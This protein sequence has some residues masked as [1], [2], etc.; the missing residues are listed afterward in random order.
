[1]LK[2][3][4][5]PAALLLAAPAL[6]QQK[7]EQ[8]LDPNCPREGSDRPTGPLWLCNGRL[9]PDYA[10]AFVYPAAATQNPALIALLREQAEADQA[11]MAQES[12][13]F[14]TERPGLFT[15][16]AEWRMDALTPELAAASGTLR[17]YTGGAH[18]GLEYRAI[19]IDRR[20]GHRIALNELFAPNLFEHSLFGRKI[21]GI[22]AVQASFCRALTAQVRERR[23]QPAA[24]VACPDIEDQ[25]VTFVCSA[26][27]RIEAMRALI[28]PYAVGSWAEGPYEVDFPVDAQMIGNMKRR[29]RVAFGLAEERRGRRRTCTTAP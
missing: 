1:M 28:E 10:F 15:Y 29:Y 23:E 8:P 16:D 3:F 25:P 21:R 26:R 12:E 4:L 11:R 2:R 18:G 17:T 7:A 6:A 14:G 19:L 20:Q 9:T 5:I 24:E 13:A 22:R 27:G